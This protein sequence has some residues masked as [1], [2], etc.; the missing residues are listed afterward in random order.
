MSTNL[1]LP[2]FVGEEAWEARGEGK[3]NLYISKISRFEKV[4]WMAG[5][6]NVGVVTKGKVTTVSG[7]IG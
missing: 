1:L 5:E 7:G 2:G 4:V 3:D 6:W